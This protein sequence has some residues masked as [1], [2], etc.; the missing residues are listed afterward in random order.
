FPVAALATIESFY[1]S[2]HDALP[3]FEVIALEIRD[4]GSLRLVSSL[5]EWTARIHPIAASE[6]TRAALIERFPSLDNFLTDAEEFWKHHQDRKS[7]RLNS[8]HQIISYAVFC[9]K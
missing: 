6:L 2:L 1:H 7:T 3:I 8:S 5:P 9:L 4:D